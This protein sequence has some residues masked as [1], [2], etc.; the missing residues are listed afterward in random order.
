M[1]IENEQ[2]IYSF[3]INPNPLQIN[4]YCDNDSQE[5]FD[6]DPR[7]IMLNN[8][9]K[10]E[11][12]LERAAVNQASK[13]MRHDWT[14]PGIIAGGWAGDENEAVK[15]EKIYSPAFKGL[16]TQE[17][18]KKFCAKQYPQ[19]DQQVCVNTFVFFKPHDDYDTI[20]GSDQV[21]PIMNYNDHEKSVY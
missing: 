11:E 6:Q 4:A 3:E 15:V 16:S 7:L 19:Y 17:A 18:M 9:T 13:N 5:L 21:E 14:I 2:F 20:L 1:R 8:A 12:L 10:I